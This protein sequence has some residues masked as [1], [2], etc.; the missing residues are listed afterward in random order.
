MSD[1]GTERSRR[2]RNWIVEEFKGKRMKS[3]FF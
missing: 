3:F 2:N 1:R